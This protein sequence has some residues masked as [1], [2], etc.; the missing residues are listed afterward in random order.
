[1][2]IVLGAGAARGGAGPS[3]TTRGRSAGLVAIGE[4]VDVPLEDAPAVDAFPVLLATATLAV[5][6]VGLVGKPG[7][8][9]PTVIVV[10]PVIGP[11]MIAVVAVPFAV[12]FAL[13]F[14]VSLP[15][16]FA[17]TITLTIAVIATTVTLPISLPITVAIMTA[18]M[19]AVPVPVSI[20]Q[21]VD[22]RGHGPAI[23]QQ[24]ISGAAGFAVVALALGHGMATLG[25]I[26]VVLW[27]A[28]P[29]R[30]SSTAMRSL[31]S[32]TIAVRAV[33]AAQ[34]LLLGLLFLLPKTADVL[35]EGA[36]AGFVRGYGLEGGDMSKTG[37]DL[38]VSVIDADWR[39][40]PLH[41]RTQLVQRTALLTVRLAVLV[42]A[43]DPLLGLGLD[44]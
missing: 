20:P 5:V 42:R 40:H 33:T 14:T 30:T 28:A 22:V 10:A 18:I 23:G 15:I 9:G 4:L 11:A 3:C 1:M 32:I 8:R 39:L 25:L 37:F 41:M 44:C 19:T 34:A 35:F 21:R 26:T 27:A 12:P 38:L 36:P 31:T 13:T 17:V 7:R 43:F 24:N 2:V 6:V 16:A 29:S